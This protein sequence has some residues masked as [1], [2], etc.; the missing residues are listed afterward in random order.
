L[1]RD[2]IEEFLNSDSDAIF[3]ENIDFPK[4]AEI[5][6]KFHTNLKLQRKLKTNIKEKYSSHASQAKLQESFFSILNSLN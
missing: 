6:D 5:I 2:G 4:I 3:V 1:K